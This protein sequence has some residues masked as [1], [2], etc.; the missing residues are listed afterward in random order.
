VVDL[1]LPVPSA[2]EA[3]NDDGALLE[4]EQEEALRGILVELRDYAERHAAAKAAA[5]AG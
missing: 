5:A 3:F 1:E 2:E 4:T